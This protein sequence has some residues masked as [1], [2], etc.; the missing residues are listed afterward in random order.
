MNR[1]YRRKN[2]KDILPKEQRFTLF[3]KVTFFKETIDNCLKYIK[4]HRTVNPPEDFFFE[5]NIPVFFIA[6]KESYEIISIVDN[7]D[8]ETTLKN[9]YKRKFIL[10]NLK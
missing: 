4:R 2:K 3:E 9:L 5:T 8:R 6:Q 1:E 10:E 7:P